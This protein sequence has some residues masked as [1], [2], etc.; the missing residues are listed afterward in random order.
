M[1]MTKG[2][3]ATAMALVLML[4]GCGKQDDS[5]APAASADGSAAAAPA[6]AGQDWTQTAAVTP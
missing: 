5:A 1:S 4:G 2:F 6:A 3:A